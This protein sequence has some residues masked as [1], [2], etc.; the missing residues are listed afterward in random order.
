M[1]KLY[2]LLGV[3][4]LV[5]VLATP[6]LASKVDLS[7]ILHYSNI[8]IT[9]DGETIYPTD[10]DKTKEPFTI[11]GTTYVPVRD[12]FEALGYNVEWD[13]S[14]N[15]VV[16]TSSGETQTDLGD[17]VTTDKGSIK[18]FTTT[19]TYGGAIHN[20]YGIPYAEAPVG[21]LRWE[22]AK[23]KTAWTTTLDCTQFKSASYQFGSDLLPNFAA[24]QQSEDCLYLNVISPATTT[25]EKLP[26]IVWF[27]GG[28]LSM[29]AGIESTYNLTRLP[30]QGC[31]VVTVNTRLGAFG[32]LAS[33]LQSSSS[34]S[35]D[36]GDFIMSDMTAALKW[37]QSNAA[38]FGGDPS[39]VTIAGESGGGAKVN[40]LVASPKAAGLFNKAILQSGIA[41]GVVGGV[42]LATAKASGD[43]L[44]Q[45][46]GVT[47]IEQA[48][49]LSADKILAAANELNLS[50]NF[51]TD[52]YYLNQTPPDAIIS[53][54]YNHVSVILGANDG[55][56]SNLA[57]IMNLIPTSTKMLT[58][59]TNEGDSVYTYLFDQ[60]PANWRS[61][62]GRAVHSMDLAY[63]FGDYDNTAS[64]FNG[65]PWALETTFWMT[66]NSIADFLAPQLTSVDK[67]VSEEMMDMWVQFAKTGNPSIANVTWEKWS[68]TGDGYLY[69]GENGSNHT[70]M[71]SGF[72]SLK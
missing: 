62:G 27:H 36:S 28:G 34:G 41:D 60:V 16:I 33:S 11:N 54:N 49:A 10:V 67:Q 51:I 4:I 44:M 59:M 42:D 22:D 65:G 63:M 19:G 31:I 30:E 37:V 12:V 21:D 72:S 43:Q 39:N 9:V 57:Q 7:K 26:V 15:T 66:N 18:G 6:V 8:S 50:Y 68:A 70:G 35:A 20:Y 56:L 40:A 29:G 46:L 69:I 32:L 2:K 48:R 53:G 38:S 64:T 5:L 71:N 25:D 1:K 23:T 61:L 58:A 3:C 55:E 14:T 24:L 47:T 52:G 17:T 13:N 45:K